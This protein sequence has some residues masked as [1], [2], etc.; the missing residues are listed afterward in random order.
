MITIVN[1][2]G[3]VWK[4]LDSLTFLAWGSFRAGLWNC[5][6]W[7]FPVTGLLEVPDACG[8]DLARG[9]SISP[10]FKPREAWSEDA[11]SST[12]W[13]S[14]GVGGAGLWSEVSSPQP[15]LTVRTIQKLFSLQTGSSL[16]QP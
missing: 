5:L 12:C 15:S 11:A 8:R 10:P 3:V 16:L 6:P 13:A 2:S 7:D 14:T 4:S 1:F 9:F